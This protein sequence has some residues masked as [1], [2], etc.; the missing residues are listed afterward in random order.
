MYD[1]Q[2]QQEPKKDRFR[3][4]R[5]LILFIIIVT[6]IFIA[7]DYYSA[8]VQEPINFAKGQSGDVFEVDCPFPLNG[9]NHVTCYHL[10]TEQ[11][12]A[13]PDGKLLSILAVKIDPLPKEGEETPKL[14]PDPFLYLEGGPG[15]ASIYGEP[16]D[17]G[18]DG[19]MRAFYS[20]VLQ[21]GRS[22]IAVDTRGLGFSR[23]ALTCPEADRAAWH[24]LTEDPE[25]RN[26]ESIFT[27]YRNC[28]QNL[29]KAGIDLGQYDSASI[30]KDLA[31]LRKGLSIKQWNIYGVS[32]GAQ[33]A[34]QLL[35]HDREGVRRVIFDSPSYAHVTP[36]QDDEAAFIRTLKLLDAYCAEMDAENEASYCPI[37]EAQETVT[38]RLDRTLAKLRD[39]PILLRS[40]S[41]KLPI[42]LTDRESFL[43]LHSSLYSETG[44]EDFLWDLQDFADLENGWLES[45]SENSAYWRELL[46]FIYFDP[47]ASSIVQ[48][49]TSCI[50]MDYDPETAQA[51]YVYSSE[52]ID[53]S[54]RLCEEMGL[55][56]N[57]E[58]INASEFTGVPSLTLSG[59]RDVITPPDYGR[60]L[61][62]DMDG[63]WL[64]KLEGAHGLAFVEGADCVKEI[65]TDFLN[66]AGEAEQAECLAENTALELVAN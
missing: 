63:L 14:H 27:P 9:D 43:I 15:Y 40:L 22:L 44:F 34:L 5:P 49:A 33:T 13:A 21:T 8:P 62:E 65:M 39:D 51:G 59:Y 46:H 4:Y 58:N 42:Y 47:L 3:R 19:V 35:R 41:L 18:E 20:P 52:E 37:K 2:Y 31:I 48:N 24:W 25:T 45:F 53:F 16:G 10:I 54:R 55:S 50:E 23:P 7:E 6:I 29:Q 30:A 17:F 36:W 12:H 1:D 57:G 60:E 66:A 32:Y 28:I 26:D 61:A 56:F 38:E 64:L 11:N